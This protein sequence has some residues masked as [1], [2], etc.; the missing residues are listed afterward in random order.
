MQKKAGS[1]D[2]VEATRMLQ[3][4]NLG[5]NIVNKKAHKLN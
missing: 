3:W 2:W 5:E 4:T 1:G